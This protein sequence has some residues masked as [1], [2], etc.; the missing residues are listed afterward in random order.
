L[1]GIFIISFMLGF[2]MKDCKD[3]IIGINKNDN[4][5]VFS[6]EKKRS[7]IENIKKFLVCMNFSIIES[8]KLFSLLGNSDNNYSE[9]KYSN[10]LYSDVHFCFERSGLNSVIFF[11]NEKVVVSIF[12][13]EVDQKKIQNCLDKYF[14]FG[15]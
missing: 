14:E 15:N 8:N 2:F 1:G 11:G 4:F 10:N 3:T 5:F 12:G 9:R 6:I 13:E 7:T